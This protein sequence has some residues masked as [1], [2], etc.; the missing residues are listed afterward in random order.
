MSLHVFIATFTNLF[1][2]DVMISGV[3]FVEVTFLRAL[4]L[5]ILF[6]II[7]TYRGIYPFGPSTSSI[8][9]RFLFIRSIGG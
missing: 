3:T 7:L 8:T 1:Y 9:K 5:L 4:V 2:K 6:S